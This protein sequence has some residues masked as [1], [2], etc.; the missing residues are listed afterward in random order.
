MITIIHHLVYK[1]AFDGDVSDIDKKL[2]ILTD[3][4]SKLN[5]DGAIKKCCEINYALFKNSD[6]IE[7]QLIS[8]HFSPQSIK[9]I[10]WFISK[11]RKKN[12]SADFIAFWREQII[13]MIFYIFQHCPNNKGYNL[14]DVEFNENFSK[15]ALLIGELLNNEDTE[16]QY[17]NTGDLFNDCIKSLPALKVGLGNANHISKES[18]FDQVYRGYN[19]FVERLGNKTLPKNRSMTFDKYF[20]DEFKISLYDCYA[21]ILTLVTHLIYNNESQN[22]FIINRETFHKHINLPEVSKGFTDLIESLSQELPLFTEQTHNIPDIPE[23][24]RPIIEFK[25]LLRT[26]P[27]IKL[28]KNLSV[29]SDITYIIEDFVSKGILFFLSQQPKTKNVHTIYGSCFE[30]YVC[31][32]LKQ[33]HISGEFQPNRKLSPNDKK[34]K[35]EVDAFV[36]FHK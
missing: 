20:L 14:T 4:L 5:R 30:G 27:I 22:N 18:I 28:P 13:N 35:L 16:G 36:K 21:Y 24:K 32:L 19:I 23:T 26:K 34:D 29:I 31:T 3:C 33:R 25:R 9:R 8:E 10:N 2:K 1:N 6:S 7:E 11:Q 15:S 17:P 12:V